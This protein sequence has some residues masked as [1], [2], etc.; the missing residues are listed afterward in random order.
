MV[1]KYQI[2]NSLTYR[3]RTLCGVFDT[4]AV[5]AAQHG[6]A[7]C[8]LEEAKALYKRL[9]DAKISR[10]E[11]RTALIASSL[12]LSCKSN[13]V[14]RSVKEIA[15]MFDIRVAAMTKGCRIFQ[16]AVQLQL[17][18]SAPSDFVGRFC[19]R[20]GVDAAATDF[21]RRIVHRADELGILS[22][23]TPP[24]VVSGA[25]M[26]ANVELGVGITRKDL[27]EACMVSPA[28]V[29]KCYKRLVEVRE[30]L[31]TPT[32]GPKHGKR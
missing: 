18:S 2:W 7:P 11:N 23:A 1:Q 12:Y 10:G 24:S 32:T 4:L 21:A 26:M 15:A 28:T 16:Q 5:N 19:S 25:I 6:I 20:L 30:H 9:A 29:V 31:M 22:E 13:H 27:A 14:P 8:I 17:D 3:E